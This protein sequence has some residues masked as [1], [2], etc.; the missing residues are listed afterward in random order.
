MTTAAVPTD[1]LGDI[2]LREGFLSREKLTHALAEQRSSGMPL[3]YILAKQGLVPEVEI[4]RIVARQLR[5]GSADEAARRIMRAL[6]R[7]RKVY[8][9]PWQMSLVMRATR[10]L[11]DWVLARSMQ[12]Y[13]IKPPF[14]Q[15][16][17]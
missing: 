6:Y 16:L 8:N 13:N 2:L 9:F 5:A 14:P 4:T 10:W 1:R 7:R 3:G 17:K 15:S 12:K 11:P